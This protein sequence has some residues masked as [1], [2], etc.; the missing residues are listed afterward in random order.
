MKNYDHLFIFMNR[1]GE[2]ECKGNCEWRVEL[3][4]SKEQTVPFGEEQKG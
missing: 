3:N 2:A 4:F 1:S